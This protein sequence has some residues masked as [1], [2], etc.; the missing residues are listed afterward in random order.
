MIWRTKNG[1]NFCSRSLLKDLVL[2]RQWDRRVAPALQELAGERTTEVLPALKN[3]F[4]EGPHPSGLVKEVIR[5]FIAAR[6]LSGRPVAL[7]TGYERAGGKRV[8]GR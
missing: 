7:S 8:G 3:I 4:F 6:R 1:W 2:S 5:K